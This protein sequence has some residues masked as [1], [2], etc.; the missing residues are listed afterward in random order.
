MRLLPT[1]RTSDTNGHGKHGTGGL[2]LRTVI[3]EIASHT[4]RLF[5][6]QGG[7]SIQRSAEREVT[8]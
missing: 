7:L 5:R 4:G 3:Y 2:D 8:A 6:Q 1:P